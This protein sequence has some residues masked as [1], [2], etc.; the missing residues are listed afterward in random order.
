MT[1]VEQSN[2]LPE[3]AARIRAE[4]Q[5]TADALKSSVE[6]GIA[7]GELLI[8]AKA[9]VP[10]G[11]WLPWLKENCAM[12]ERTAQLYMRLA[13]NRKEIEEQ[14]RNDV[15]DLTMAEAAALLMLSSDARRLIRF[16]Q[17]MGGLDPEEFVQ[18]AL[19]QRVALVGYHDK[20]YRVFAHCTPEG[21]RDWHCLC[22]FSASSMATTPTQRLNTPNTSRRSSSWIRTN[23]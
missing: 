18:A 15:A 2:Y 21:E 17:N 19:D 8:E 16:A 20:G 6:H 9:K 1:S 3:L 10:H 4:H 5:A 23:G 12:S 11:Q 13:K 7:A 14:I 22:S